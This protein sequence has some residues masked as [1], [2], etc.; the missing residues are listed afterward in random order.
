[1]LNSRI[2]RVEKI[3]AAE[4]QVTI[5]ETALTQNR[6]SYNE[7]KTLV[8]ELEAGNDKTSLTARLEVVNQILCF[9]G[10]IR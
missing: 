8:D 6:E 5:A 1:M 3:I 4:S 9:Q 10:C 2:E 7:A